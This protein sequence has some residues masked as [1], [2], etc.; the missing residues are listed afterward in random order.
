MTV[1]VVVTCRINEI[2]KRHQPDAESDAHGLSGLFLLVILVLLALLVLFVLL[3]L[4]V[5]LQILLAVRLTRLE[6]KVVELPSLELLTLEVTSSKSGFDFASN[7][8]FTKRELATMK[9][10]SGQWTKQK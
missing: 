9:S 8:F 1:V 7:N 3:V 6:F 10:V 4:L 5:A 2:E